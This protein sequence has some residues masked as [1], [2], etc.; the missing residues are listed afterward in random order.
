MTDI[1]QHPPTPATLTRGRIAFMTVLVVVGLIFLGWGT[2][3]YLRP[4]P[5]P[6]DLGQEAKEYLRSRNVAPLS[7]P[8]QQLLADPSQFLV[9]SQAHSLV[10]LTAPDFDL[11]DHTG[12]HQRL[13]EL[14][15]RGPLVLVF[16]YGYH[17]NHCVAQLFALNGDIARFRELGAEVVAVSADPPE[18]T[19]QR[20]RQ[21]GVF[22]FPVLSD[23]GNQVA[24]RLRR[25]PPSGSGQGQSASARH[26][27]D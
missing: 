7:A 16:Y 3:R 21:Y 22:D 1:I 24:P 23:P 5:A 10:G 11:V 26:L 20:F 9:K 4:P 17:C 8:L 14:L 27:R 12:Q 19:R 13:H 2:V 25:L 6:P 18:T 15:E